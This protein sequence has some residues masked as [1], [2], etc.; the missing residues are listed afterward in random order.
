MTAN[1]DHLQRLI[2]QINSVLAQSPSPLPWKTAAQAA[3]Q[4]QVLQSV[5][6]YL[7]SAL[8]ERNQSE[9][10]N[11]V[12]DR[13]QETMQAVVE[14]MNSLRST[15]LRPLHAEVATLMQQRNALV[16]EIRQLEAHRQLIEHSSAPPASAPALNENF[17]AGHAL[18]TIDT[19][20]SVMFDSLQKDIQAYQDS[21]SQG[22]GKMHHLGCQSEALFSRLVERLAEH[23]THDAAFLQSDSLPPSSPPALAAMPYA[24]AE[25]AA[26]PNVLNSGSSLDSIQQLTELVDQ[27]AAEVEPIPVTVTAMPPQGEA[28][29]TQKSSSNLEALTELQ[30]L[31]QAGEFAQTASVETTRDQVDRT[32]DPD[33]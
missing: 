7:Q 31:F 5:Q 32:L 16:R 3:Y 18:S 21:L 15:L 13:A 4:R 2:A 22:I 12:G 11:S 19:A 8:I 6:A 30:M 29:P 26:M 14:E 10:F 24:G 25:F 28:V 27:L 33:R 20:L 23:S 17:Q 1:Q 9:S